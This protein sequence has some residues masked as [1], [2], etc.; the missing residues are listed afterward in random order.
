MA[1]HEHEWSFDE[2]AAIVGELVTGLGN[3]NIEL[4]EEGQIVT[5]VSST[6]LEVGNTGS[7]S[8]STAYIGPLTSSRVQYHWR[9]SDGGSNSVEGD[10]ALQSKEG[11]KG[12]MPGLN[13]KDTYLV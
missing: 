7:Y 8:W 5:L 4:W 13:E 3:V 10:F 2:P 12:I 6:C 1:V 11:R 9:M